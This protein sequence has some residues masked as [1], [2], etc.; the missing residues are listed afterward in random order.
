MTL[1]NTELYVLFIIGKV[2]WDM[3]EMYSQQTIVC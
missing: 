1:Q 3:G 2:N